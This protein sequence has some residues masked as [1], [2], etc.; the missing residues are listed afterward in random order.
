MNMLMVYVHSVHEQSVNHISTELPNVQ[1][2]PKCRHAYLY[3]ITCQ[4]LPSP[5]VH[6]LHT[7]TITNENSLVTVTYMFTSPC[8]LFR[9]SSKQNIYTCS[10]GGDLRCQYMFL[11]VTDFSFV[12][13]EVGVPFATNDGALTVTRC[14]SATRYAGWFL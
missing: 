13:S 5:C 9:E 14:E 10:D 1:V 12:S 11:A 7:P 4:Y 6:W 3:A 2:W 8:G